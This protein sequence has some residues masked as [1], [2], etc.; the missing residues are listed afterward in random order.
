MSKTIWKKLGDLLIEK[1]LPL[2]GAATGLPGGAVMGALIADVVGGNA[3]DSEVLLQRA[4]I[5]LTSPEKISALKD[6]EAQ[7]RVALQE[8]ITRQNIVQIEADTS[9]LREVNQTMRVE[10]KVGGWPGFWRPFWGVISAVAWAFM[11]GCIGVMLVKN[12]AQLA[13]ALTAMTSLQYFWLIPLIILGVASHHR[14]KEK[15]F[16]AGEQPSSVLTTF[17]NWIG[18]D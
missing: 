5:E 16:A 9:R 12:P 17:K 13:T 4:K 10:A 14:G 6:I 15:R 7:N 8:L 2:L 18:K 1:G 3:N 11:A